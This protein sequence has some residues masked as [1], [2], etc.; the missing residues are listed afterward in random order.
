MPSF[1]LRARIWTGAAVLAL[2]AFV[3]LRVLVPTRDQALAEGA[4]AVVGLIAL[5][6]AV[7]GVA[8]RPRD[9]LTWLVT[10]AV[11]LWTLGSLTLAVRFGLDALPAFPSISEAFWLGSY[12][13]M[14]AAVLLTISRHTASR[15]AALWLDGLIAGVGTAALGAVVLLPRI[16]G[17]E[18]SGLG[19][20]VATAFP[21]AD[22]LLLGA[23]A[24]GLVVTHRRPARLWWRLGLGVALIAATDLVFALRM[25]NPEAAWSNVVDVGWP[26]GLLLLGSAGWMARAEREVP[27]VRRV[28]VLPLLTIAGAALLLVVDHYVR[29]P[30]LGLW[31]AVAA[32][33][34]A[35]TRTA[36]VMR[37]NIALLEAERQALT[38]DLTG[39][40]NRRR[41]FRDL[42]ALLADGGSTATVALFDLDGFKA[43]NDGRGH[44]AG[45]ALLTD[46]GTRLAAAVAGDGAAYRLGGDEFCVI[47]DGARASQGP[48]VDRALDALRAGGVGASGGAVTVPG[49]A[50]GASEALRIADARMYA[51]KALR[52]ELV[53]RAA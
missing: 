33:V 41:L 13:P 10:A 45:D 3:V 14:Y 17:D 40:G 38:D 39:L 5:V 16:A 6:A 20:L 19:A 29:V 44:V 34:L 31:L 4:S 7:A 24:S 49:E 47:A 12:L 48:A 52:R 21:S 9:P 53:R 30:G 43:Y 23:V 37:A 32:L 50:G 11:G 42:D 2:V 35:L 18:L 51:D 15:D 46:L 27:A 1:P 36:L 22:V 8:R 26:A 25:T 28:P